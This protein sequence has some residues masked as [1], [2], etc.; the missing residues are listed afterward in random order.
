MAC[1]EADLAC[2]AFEWLRENEFAAGVL[3][4]FVAEYGEQAGGVVQ[5]IAGFVRE[6][7]EKIIAAAGF[8]FGVWR[9]WVYLEHIL[10]KR[11]EEY[12]SE[13]DGRLKTAAQDVL[14]ALERPSPG[15]PGNTDLRRGS[16]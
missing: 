9:W 13:S 7:G 4:K 5:A 8:S 10:H 3:T 6:H 1:G 14:T 11:L 16:I 12:L 2:F 15:R